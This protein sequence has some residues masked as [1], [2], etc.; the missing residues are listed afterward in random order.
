MNLG[1]IIPVHFWPK[2]FWQ[3]WK[4]T[5]KSCRGRNSA[6]PQGDQGG[7]N[8]K[9][10]LLFLLTGVGDCEHYKF[11]DNWGRSLGDVFRGTQVHL[12]MS[13]RLLNHYARKGD[14]ILEGKIEIWSRLL[15]KWFPDSGS[16]P[17]TREN[18][19]RWKL[20]VARE[21]FWI[22]LPSETNGRNLWEWLEIEKPQRHWINVRAVRWWRQYT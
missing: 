4:S 19:R 5:V 11:W 9:C 20:R 10:P 1:Q 13:L 8:K 15:E 17:W 22:T 14:V 21:I 7:S 6:K 3:E 18:G 16:S 12:A 2:P